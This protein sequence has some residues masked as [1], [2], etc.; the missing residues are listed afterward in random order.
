MTK[1]LF[2][3]LMFD[4]AMELFYHQENMSD[5]EIGEKILYYINLDDKEKEKN[6]E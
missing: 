4:C 2:K 1:E 6:K 5:K 3:Q